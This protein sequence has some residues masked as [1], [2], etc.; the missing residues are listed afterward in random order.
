MPADRTLIDNEQEWISKY[1]A[2]LD[3]VP[4]PKSRFSGFAASLGAAIA[5]LQS[6]WSNLISGR[7]AVVSPQLAP[8][9]CDPVA[10]APALHIVSP[11]VAP[12]KPVVSTARKR[13]RRMG[14]AKASTQK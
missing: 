12:R 14:E 8:S 7:T 11:P 3:H 10:A 1:R 5:F 13:K 4:T 9:P 2:A 6:R